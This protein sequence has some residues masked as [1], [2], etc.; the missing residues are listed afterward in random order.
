MGIGSQ[1]FQTKELLHQTLV[2]LA[3]ECGRTPGSTTTM[4][5]ATTTRSSACWPELGS[6]LDEA[7]TTLPE[8][9][10]AKGLQD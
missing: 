7:T 4:G 9:R 10:E 5:G 1:R 3:T 6:G 8:K 2:V